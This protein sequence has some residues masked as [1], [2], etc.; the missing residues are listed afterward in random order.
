MKPFSRISLT[1]TAD[2]VAL[3]YGWDTFSELNRLLQVLA[4]LN[5]TE[6]WSERG[7]LAGLYF[8]HTESED[9]II[10]LDGVHIFV[11]LEEYLQL[12]V[13]FLE[14][15]AE[16]DVAPVLAELRTLYGDL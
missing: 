13:A 7:P 15:L 11:K 6:G 4:W 1:L 5:V 2:Q 16:P 12:E 8:P 14:A 3:A 10:S 9:V